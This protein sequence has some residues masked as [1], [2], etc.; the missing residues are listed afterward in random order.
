MDEKKSLMLADGAERLGTYGPVSYTNYSQ[1]YTILHWCT[2]Q[3]EKKSKV[4][5]LLLQLCSGGRAE[6]LKP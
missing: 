3:R 2:W 1:F 4:S 6:T 5:E